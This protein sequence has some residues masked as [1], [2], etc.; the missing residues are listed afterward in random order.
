MN[1]VPLPFIAEGRTAGI[2]DSSGCSESSCQQVG[3]LGFR[4]K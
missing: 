4:M 1:I 2:V 3:S